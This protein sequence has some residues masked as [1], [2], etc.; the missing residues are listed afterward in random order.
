MSHCQIVLMKLRQEINKGG[1]L[2][3]S[4]KWN[5]N[6]HNIGKRSCQPIC[7]HITLSW[8]NIVNMKQLW[9]MQ[10]SFVCFHPGENYGWRRIQEWLSDYNIKSGKNVSAWLINLRMHIYLGLCY[11]FCKR[12]PITII[13]KAF[14]DIICKNVEKRY[15]DRE[16]TRK[17]MMFGFSYTLSLPQMADKPIAFLQIRNIVYRLVFSILLCLYIKI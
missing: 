9:K 13:A 10:S 1:K 2:L 5:K 7:E 17:T 3:I 15:S 14:L 16:N 6:L 4:W 11:Y 8:H 12:I